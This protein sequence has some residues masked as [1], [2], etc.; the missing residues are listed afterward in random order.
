MAE[1][2]KEMVIDISNKACLEFGFK[3]K[4]RIVAPIGE[5]ATV[6][7]VGPPCDCFG[8]QVA[9]RTGKNIL[10]A[11][12]D[13]LNG[14]VF[15]LGVSNLRDQGFR[16]KSEAEAEPE[17]TLTHE[18][19]SMDDALFKVDISDKICLEFGFKHGDRI[20]SPIGNKGTV[21][22]VSLRTHR[23]KLSEKMLW[24]ILD[25]CDG[26]ALRAGKKDFEKSDFKKL[27]ENE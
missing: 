13:E 17:L 10:L 12:N 24:V 15:S 16:L 22:G 19:M 11:T 18:I 2:G 14:E 9:G 4:D 20:V 7:G 25:G 6:M 26:K 27:E 23:M 3:H 5:E 1:N 8:C 21:A